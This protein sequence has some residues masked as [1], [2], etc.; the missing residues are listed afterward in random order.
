[1]GLLW[2]LRGEL[3]AP[4]WRELEKDAKAK[5]VDLLIFDRTAWALLAAPEGPTKYEGLVPSEPPD[6][7][8]ISEQGQPIYVVDCREVKGPLEVI[9]ALGK[10]AEELLEKIGDPDTV[11]D[12]LGKAF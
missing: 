1:M 6:G 3:E 4:G 2:L 7:L 10:E 9:K 12:R 8:Y 11:L 5:D